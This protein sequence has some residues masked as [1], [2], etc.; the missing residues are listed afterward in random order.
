[1]DSMFLW[2][3]T[4]FGR[5]SGEDLLKT[6]TVPISSWDM[7]NNLSISVPFG[8]NLNFKRIVNVTLMV[9]ND[10]LTEKHNVLNG[11]MDLYVDATDVHIQLQAG[12]IF[13]N[14]NYSSTTIQ[15]G[16]IVIWFST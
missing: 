5:W 13:D 9:N 4:F 10:N 11:T 16:E 12:S 8:N 2:F 1:M 7:Q 14:A 15:R 3:R 6:R